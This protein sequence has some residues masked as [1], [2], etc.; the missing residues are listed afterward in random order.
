MNYDLEQSL[1][2][3]PGQSYMTT[4]ILKDIDKYIKISPHMTIKD[5]YIKQLTK[6]SLFKENTDFPIVNNGYI[7]M[8]SYAIVVVP[9]QFL[10][11]N[12]VNFDNLQS[13]E[14]FILDSNYVNM[15]KEDIINHLRNSIAHVRYSIIKSGEG[16]FFEFKDKY[17]ENS[18]ENFK[19]KIAAIDYPKFLDEFFKNYYK[20]YLNNLE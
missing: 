2:Q 1:I 7:M 4:I 17:N 12:R 6:S 14:Y 9:Y 19:A 10:K 3:V 13:L 15:A 18:S 16:D 5:Y 8:L 11:K 20:Y